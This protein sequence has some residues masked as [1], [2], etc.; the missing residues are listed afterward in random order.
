MKAA[1]SML[2]GWF[3]VTLGFAQSVA[4]SA[5]FRVSAGAPSPNVSLPAHVGA[6]TGELTL[7]ADFA[8]ADESGVP[9]FLVNRTN[10]KVSLGSED[11]DVYIK[12][13]RQLTTG[14][15]KRAQAHDYSW[16]GNSYG[17]LSLSSGMHYRLHGYRPIHGKPAKVRYASYGSLPVSSNI[18][19]GIFAPEDVA[20]AQLDRMPLQNVPGSVSRWFEINHP[21]R[22]QKLS[23]LVAAL[24]MAE[25]MGEMPAIRTGAQRWVEELENLEDLA[26]EE[27]RALP[28]IREILKRN[29][30]RSDSLQRLLER[31]FAAVKSANKTTAEFGSLEKESVLTWNVIRE[32]GA[33]ETSAYSQSHV[34]RRSDPAVWKQVLQLAASQVLT[35]PNEAAIGM[36]GVLGL[37]PLADELLSDDAFEPLLDSDRYGA[38][39]VAA[40]TLSRRGKWERLAE[41]GFKCKPENQVRILES[42]AKGPADEN[43]SDIR[44]APDDSR[45]QKFWAHVLRTRPLEASAVLGIQLRS[46]GNSHNPFYG[47]AFDEVRLYWQREIERNDRE[48][49][50]FDIGPRGYQQRFSVQFIAAW[51]NKKDIPLLRS[52][53]RFRGYEKASG[54]R[55]D[56]D[57]L[58]TVPVEI[59]TFSV[60]KTAAD[61]LKSLD[62]SIPSDVVF[63][64]EVKVGDSSAK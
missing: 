34:F 40:N 7:F 54:S 44:I 26:P 43:G 38:A 18:G 25:L 32:I 57:S 46:G 29:W 14:E 6:K 37:S 33:I 15:W 62:E 48:G 36:S 49:K 63:S 3:G 20:D 17:G 24:R 56:K 55:Y 45:E 59:H 50:D 16:C 9:L 64:E 21:R 61:A 1:A 11:G 12:L 51:K 42:L 60:R 35:A 19:D 23:T 10:N 2:I 22:Q 52:V 30:G 53:L 47:A 58:R 5:R 31:S 39:G 41:L 28:L 4:P 13:E 27:Q 8:H